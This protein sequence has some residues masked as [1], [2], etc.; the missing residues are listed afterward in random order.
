VARGRRRHAEHCSSA[1]LAQAGGLCGRG[2]GDESAEVHGGEAIAGVAEEDDSI[3]TAAL[4]ATPRSCCLYA[5]WARD[6]FEVQAAKCALANYRRPGWS[7]P[8]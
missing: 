2:L 7:I 1:R 5:P 4:P 3:W 8:S 6:A